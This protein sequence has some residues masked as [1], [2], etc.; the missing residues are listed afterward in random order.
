MFILNDN[1]V[2]ANVIHFLTK[3]LK[4]A[5]N[6]IKIYLP[7]ADYK[8]WIR[9]NLN[10]YH[11][12]KLG[13]S[14]PYNSA[15]LAKFVD[16]PYKNIYIEYMAKSSTILKNPSKVDRAL[17]ILALIGEVRGVFKCTEDS[18]EKSHKIQLKAQ[19]M[20]HGENRAMK[21]QAI[22][23]YKDNREMLGS[24][25]KASYEISQKIVPAS[26]STIKGWLK[27]V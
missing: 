23:Y 1:F 20:R 16:E 9:E 4:V 13:V 22:Q 5:F 19:A 7:N 3:E 10:I 12:Y 14:F 8:D 24:K 2:V 25:E 26:S 21:E 15:L 27:N 11:D 18:L 17:Q 6:E